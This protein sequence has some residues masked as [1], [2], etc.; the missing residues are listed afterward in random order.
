[1][2]HD[3]HG[4]HIRK[5]RISILDKCNFRC[6]YCMPLDATFIPEKQL[7]SPRE[8]REISS[9]LVDLGITQIRVTGGEPTVRKEFKEIMTLLAKLP[10]KKLC[11]TTN[12]LLLSRHLPML[13]DI[14]CHHINISMDSLSEEKFN[15]IT[16]SK[17]FRLVYSTVLKAKAMGF[18]IKINT[19]LLKGMN[20]DELIDFVHFSA[21]HDIE[22][23]FL[24]LMKIGLGCRYQTS[25]FLSADEA[26]GHIQTQEDL[27]REEVEYDSTSFNFMTS[28]GGRVGFIAS[29]T[30][31][32][33]HSCSR[34]RLT[35]EGILRACLM[36]QKGINL[37]GIPSSEYKAILKKVMAM[38][39][40]GRIH[41]IDQKMYQIG[42]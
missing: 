32:F 9:T 30:K 41:H 11:L 12:G 31:P 10:L 7:L 37:H 36:T 17:G 35:D 20:D 19:L 24:E 8:I 28:S 1:M 18:H 4:R 16:R 5:L 29:E 13:K 21:E 39:P 15:T 22:V 27:T 6:F 25:H 33:C 42:G 3:D 40:T 23:R 26:I 14:G 34:L 2:M 38:K